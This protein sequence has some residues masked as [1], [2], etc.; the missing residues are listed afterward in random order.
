M[1]KQD[2]E[3]VINVLVVITSKRGGERNLCYLKT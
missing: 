1:S 3:L 2:S